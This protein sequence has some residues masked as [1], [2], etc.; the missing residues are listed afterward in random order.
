MSQPLCFL[1]PAFLLLTNYC[2]CGEE[3]SHEQNKET[4]TTYWDLPFFAVWEL[5]HSEETQTIEE[6]PEMTKKQE[7]QEKCQPF[8]HPRLKSLHSQ[9]HVVSFSQGPKSVQTS[10]LI[11]ALQT[12]NKTLIQGVG[13]KLVPEYP[14]HVP[15][16][17]CQHDT[18]QKCWNVVVKDPPPFD[19]G[20]I[21]DEDTFPDS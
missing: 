14:V 21:S 19:S 15:L 1:I 17:P 2:Q 4:E 6:L 11:V 5:S 8:P 20:S 18:R 10:T 3:V 13:Y 7:G 12:L 16:W 9:I